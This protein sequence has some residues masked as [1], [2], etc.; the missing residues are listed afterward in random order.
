MRGVY[1]FQNVYPPLVERPQPLNQGQHLVGWIVRSVFNDQVERAKLEE[2]AHLVCLSL[3]HLSKD[4]ARICW[5]LWLARQD[6]C[7]VY[8]R[9]WELLKKPPYG[10]ALEYTDFSDVVK[11]ATLQQRLIKVGEAVPKTLIACSQ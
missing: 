8:L 5:P 1:V 11:L 9:F 2:A 7:S 3:I 6:I 10:I 4:E